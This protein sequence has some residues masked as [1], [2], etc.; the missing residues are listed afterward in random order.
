MLSWI[1]LE[2]RYSP[3][4]ISQNFIGPLLGL[5]FS[6]Y[7]SIRQS[8]IAKDKSTVQRDM[9]PIEDAYLSASG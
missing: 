2:A 1:S 5:P 8:K 9:V 6:T 7:Y 3:K 4:E